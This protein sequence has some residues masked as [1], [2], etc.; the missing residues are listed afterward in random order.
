MDSY[1]D[2]FADELQATWFNLTDAD[3]I[4]VQLL[5]RTPEDVA[6]FASYITKSAF[7]KD[8]VMGK[9]FVNTQHLW[10]EY[11]RETKGMS[12][13]Q[14]FGTWYGVVKLLEKPRT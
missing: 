5:K 11:C 13:L 7:L 2:S 12:D 14:P 1:L 9:T 4:D 10:D 8:A 6:R 3:N